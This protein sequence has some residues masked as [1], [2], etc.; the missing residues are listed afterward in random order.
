MT[1]IQSKPGDAVA[2]QQAKRQRLIRVGIQPEIVEIND[3]IGNLKF[4]TG[5]VLKLAAGKRI[6]RATGG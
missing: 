5:M 4:Q 2:I 3:L 1:M 6:D